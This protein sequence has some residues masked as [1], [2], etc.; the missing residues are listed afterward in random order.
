MAGFVDSPAV[1]TDRCKVMGIEDG[2]VAALQA[3][4]ITT[5]GKLAFAADYQPGGPDNG[6]RN[7][8]NDKM[9]GYSD[10]DFSLIKR[11]CFEAFT[12]V[13]ADLRSRLEAGP[14]D[15]VRKLAGAERETRK[16]G[17]R[18]RLKGLVL[19]AELDIAHEL[20]DLCYEMS[21]SNTL[22]YIAWERLTKRD[23]EV[24]GA[25][26]ET[27]FRLDSTGSLKCSSASAESRADVSTDRRAR[28]ALQRRSLAFDLVGL[29]TYS[30][31]EL[32]NDRMFRAMDQDPVPGY[33]TVTLEQARRADVKFWQVLARETVRGLKCEVVGGEL[34]LDKAIRDFMSDPEVVFMLLPLA[35]ARASAPWNGGGGGGGKGGGGRPQPATPVK[36]AAVPDLATPVKK[37]KGAGKGKVKGGLVPAALKGC[38]PVDKDGNRICFG[39][40]LPAGC[41]S[42][43]CAKG[44]HKCIHCGGGHGAQQCQTWQ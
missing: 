23:N 25:K 3:I 22:S 43:P 20:V 17:Q 27:S 11:L 41:S 32:W 5:L 35:A 36:R 37:Q 7:F 16:E 28:L 13:T 34:P 33:A 15:T 14:S 12:F 2:Q 6:L 18:A 39:Y 44:L 19:A 29:G 42:N 8:L 40:N 9:P 1:F 38:S 31:L 24:A 21:E 4:N 26:K 10:G 30:T